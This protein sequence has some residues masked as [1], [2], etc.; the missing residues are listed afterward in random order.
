[1]NYD[2]VEQTQNKI[3]NPSNLHVFNRDNIQ[4]LA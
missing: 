2:F 1:M 4:L 3:S